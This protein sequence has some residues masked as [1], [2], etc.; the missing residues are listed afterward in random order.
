MD[1]DQFPDQEERKDAN[2]ALRLALAGA[3]KELQTCNKACKFTPELSSQASNQ[4]C[5]RLRMAIP[6][7]PKLS[8]KMT[9]VV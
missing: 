6:A 4:A 7:L 1:G 3:A 2:W 5:A 8:R 9:T